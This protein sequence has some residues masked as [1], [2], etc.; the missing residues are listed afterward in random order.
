MNLEQAHCQGLF[1][2]KLCADFLFL[3]DLKFRTGYCD[4]MCLLCVRVSKQ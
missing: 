3:R 2:Y 1:F 4:F